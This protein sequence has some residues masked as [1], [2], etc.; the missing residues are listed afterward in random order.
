MKVIIEKNFEHKGKTYEPGQTVALPEKAAQQA[1]EKGVAKNAEKIED[2]IEIKT[3]N[4][5]DNSSEG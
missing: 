1:I 2:E 3:G 4:E 5:V